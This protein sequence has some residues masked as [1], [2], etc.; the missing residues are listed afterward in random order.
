MA[1]IPPVAYVGILALAAGGA[2][3]GHS[4]LMKSAPA[5]AVA[6]VVPGKDAAASTYAALSPDLQV[7][8]KPLYDQL[9]LRKWKEA[10]RETYLIATLQVA[11]PL[12]AKDGHIV[13]SEMTTFPAADLHAIDDL[14]STAS[15]NKFGF[16][17]QEIILH[18]KAEHDWKKLYHKLG[19]DEI[20]MSYSA[21]ERQWDFAPGH[22]PDWDDL[23]TGE[24][25][26]LERGYNYAV[27][28]DARLAACG[29]TG[30]P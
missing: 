1:K 13:A 29:F 12:S 6:G 24:L 14:W 22:E 21:T 17:T 8:Y 16:K 5:A 28:L 23:H 2:F 9:V 30:Q 25:P 27:S 4:L 18:N 11:G 26:T 3:V 15:H 19:W 20:Q 7:R 10:N